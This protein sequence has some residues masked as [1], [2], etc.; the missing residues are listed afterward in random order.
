MKALLSLALLATVATAQN[1]VAQVDDPV[2]P[3]QLGDA[4]LSLDEAIRIANGTLPLAQL[5]TAERA[6]ITGTGVPTSI[7]VDAKITPSIKLLAAT[8]PITGPAKAITVRIEGINGQ[9]EIDATGM[10]QALHVRTNFADIVNLTIKNGS[11]GIVAD[12]MGNFMMNR[13]M[14][15]DGLTFTGQT[16]A[17][18]RTGTTGGGMMM[19]PMMI[20]HSTF[21]SLAT[22]IKVDDRS[23]MAAVMM[24]VEYVTFDAV[25]LAF[26]AYIDGAGMMSMCRMWRCKMPSGNQ[27]ARVRRS[28]TSDKRSMLMLVGSDFVT[29]GDCIDAEGTKLVEMAIHVHHSSFRPGK[30]KNAFLLGPADARIDWHLSENIVYGDCKITEGRLNRRLW[31]W[32]NIFRDGVIEITNLGTPQNFRWNRFENCTLRA[33]SGS[34][35]QMKH[36]SSEFDNCTIEGQSFLGDVLLEN[37]FVTNTQFTGTTSQQAVAPSPWLGNSWTSNEEP[38]IGGY[39]DLSLDLP[40]GM[41]GVWSIGIPDSRLILTQEPWRAYALSSVTV[42]LPGIY[43]FR[44]TVSIPVPNDPNLV[45]A[46]LYCTAT[47]VPYQGQAHVPLRNL[48]RGVFWTLSN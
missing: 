41:L 43:A 19:V 36:V 33:T 28:P 15:L 27:V 2:S 34:N 26:D 4:H 29:S 23:M 16:G 47:A 10:A 5:S 44:S 22:A 14:L 20:Q 38:K 9:P 37:C 12:T 32:N 45:G 30:S 40:A 7:E 39:A 17:G 8:T 46:E 3:G 48:P 24:D 31:A 21:R 35:T 6:R 42:M 18:V 1:P 13:Q 11:D 25:N